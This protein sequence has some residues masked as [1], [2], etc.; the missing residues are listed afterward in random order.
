MKINKISLIILCFNCFLALNCFA[1]T[2]SSFIVGG[3]INKFYPVAFSDANWNSSRPTELEIGRS[4]IHQDSDWRGS[5]MSKFIFH[6]TRWGNGARFTDVYIKQT[7][8]SGVHPDVSFVAGYSDMTVNSASYDFIIWL[9]GGGTTYYFKSDAIQNPLVYDGVQHALPYQEVNGPT[10]SF[11]TAVEAYVNSSGKSIDGSIYSTGRGMNYF[12]GDLALGTMDTK[13]FKLAVN[14]KIRAQ[15]I[16][17]ETAN[18]PDYVFEEDYK[19]ETLEGLESYI[20]ANKHLPEIPSAKETEANG[21]ELG[22]MNKLLLKKIEELTL[23][24]IE[25]KKGSIEQQKQLDQ[26]KKKLD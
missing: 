8:N 13:G 16:K 23:Y 25:L 15:E 10:H 26:L 3:D 18:W 22:G 24:V 21:I 17:V 11:K 5:L 9:K 2:P 6:N 1:Q 7:A 20:K 19:V 12:V 4:N 14:G